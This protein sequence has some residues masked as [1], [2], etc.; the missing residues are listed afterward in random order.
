MSAAAAWTP[1]H[2]RFLRPG[3]ATTAPLIGGGDVARVLADDV[4]DSWPVL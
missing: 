3:P 1:D 4:W 2:L